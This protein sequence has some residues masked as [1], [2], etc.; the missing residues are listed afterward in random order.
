MKNILLATAVFFGAAGAASAF[1]LGNTGISLGGEVESSYNFGTENF[2]LLFTPEV[3]VNYS[4]LALAVTTEF[5]LLNLNRNLAG[6]FHGLDFEAIYGLNE[7]IQVYGEI[8]T[9]KDFKFGD[10]VVGTRL[11]F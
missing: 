3:A 4:G 2:G 1:E 5:D 6:N 10:L 7:F 9:D 8:S 11:T